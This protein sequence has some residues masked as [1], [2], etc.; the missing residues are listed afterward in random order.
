[1]LKA[2]YILVKVYVRITF[3]ST[4]LNIALHEYRKYLFNTINGFLYV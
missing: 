1:M 4:I 2:Y 3:F